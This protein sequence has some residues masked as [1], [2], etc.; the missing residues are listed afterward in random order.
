MP[1]S[2]VSPSL[3][4]K[5]KDYSSKTMTTI[6]TRDETRREHEKKDYPM[7]MYIYTPKQI[8]EGSAPVG[9]ANDQ[10]GS[11]GQNIETPVQRE[12]KQSVSSI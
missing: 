11:R 5:K 1:S 9:S 10:V 7:S 3:L 4:E 2:I 6:Q 12:I 8:E